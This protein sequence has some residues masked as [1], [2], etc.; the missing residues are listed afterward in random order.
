M[1]AASSRDG[2]TSS[3][4]PL[5]AI[6]HVHELDETHDHRRAA[7][8]FDEIERRVIVQAAL[9]DGIDLDGSQAGGDGGLDAAQD[10]IER[11]ETAAHAGEHFA[12]PRYPG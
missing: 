7:E 9:D 2:T 10:L 6:A 4:P 12:C 8:A 3:G 5:V 1:R 11:G